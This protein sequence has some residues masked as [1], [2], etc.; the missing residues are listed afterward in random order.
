MAPI[1]FFGICIIIIIIL[2]IIILSKINFDYIFARG[3]YGE[4]CVANILSTLPQEEYFILNDIFLKNGDKTTQIDHIVVSVYGIFIIETKTYNGW[5]YGDSN[6]DYWTQNLWGNKYPLYN[7]IFQ[8]E[9]HIRFLISN[10]KEIRD[11]QLSVFPIIV[12]VNCTN[13]DIRGNNGSVLPLRYLKDYILEFDQRKLAVEDCM[14][15]VSKITEHNIL[16]KD[17]RLNHIQSVK[18]TIARYNDQITN[19]LCPRCGGQ[20][21]LRNGKYG[22]FYGCSNFPKCRF[23][24]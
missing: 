12:F 23:T 6:K 15:I 16:D 18:Q 4:T 1:I 7:P 2:L 21:I 3:K 19:G 13:F 20:L 14:N 9:G 22:N 10:F 8:N 11:K 24:R 5:I 17:E